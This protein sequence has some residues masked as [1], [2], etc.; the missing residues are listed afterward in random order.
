[1]DVHGPYEPSAEFRR[2]YVAG[3]VTDAEAAQLYKRAV[4]EPN[5][6][7]ENERQRL[8]DLYDAEIEYLDAN[9]ARLLGELSRLGIRD[10]TLILL[11]ADHGEAFGERGYY[12][13]PRFLSQELTHVPLIATGSGVHPREPVRTP[14]STLDITPTVAAVFGVEYAGPGQSLAATADQSD[15]NRVVFAQARGE[16]ADAG[17]RR[18]AAYGADGAVYADVTTQTGE[19]KFDTSTRIELKTALDTHIETDGYSSA[20]DTEQSE[21]DDTKRAA[22]DYV[23]EEVAHRLRA[24]GYTE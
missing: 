9:I 18:Y 22:K 13:H 15:S 2:K 24:L 16:A 14:V 19:R 12:E 10:E 7:T 8:I 3:R 20:T 1:M 5:T 4:A 6:L 11:T 21:A 17:V 23:E